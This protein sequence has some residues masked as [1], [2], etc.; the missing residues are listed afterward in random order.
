[1]AVS[2]LG[3]NAARSSFTPE[4]TTGVTTRYG[5]DNAQISA[6]TTALPTPIS[7]SG[8]IESVEQQI[9]SVVGAAPAL[10]QFPQ[11]PGLRQ[12]SVETH[13]GNHRIMTF[14]TSDPPYTVFRYYQ[15]LM[16]KQGWT[17]SGGASLPGYFLDFVW[18]GTTR[19]V[20]WDVDFSMEEGLSTNN[21]TVISISTRRWPTISDV[22][23]YPG[24]QG[25][26]RQSDSNPAARIE[27]LNTNYGI[28]ATPDEVALFYKSLLSSYGWWHNPSF[29]AITSDDGLVFVYQRFQRADLLVGGSLHVRAN[30][31]STGTTQVEMKAEGYFPNFRMVPIAPRP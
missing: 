28:N 7:V 13:E 9:A 1:M 4:H 20:P 15:D 11:Y 16:P 26:T 23:L 30:V 8:A 14:G 12:M 22:P 25:T 27:Y 17:Q 31:G 29:D 21:E 3:W 18:E 5:V 2:L 10:D 6:Q 24:A 19:G